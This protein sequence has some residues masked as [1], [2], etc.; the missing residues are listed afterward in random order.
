MENKG[1][2]QGTTTIVPVKVLPALVK[3][4]EIF[5]L[6]IPKEVQEKIE[7]I[8]KKISDVEWSGT[9]FY[10]H[11]GTI[12]GKDLLITALDIFVQDIGTAAYTEFDQS[13]DVISYACQ[14]PELLENE[15]QMGLIHSHNTMATFFSGTD[16]ATLNEEGNDRNHFVSLIV[17]NAGTYSAGITRKSIISQQIVQKAFYNTF[18]A[19]IIESSHEFEV[20]GTEIHWYAMNVITPEKEEVLDTEIDER[21]AEIKAE[22]AAK[23]AAAVKIIPYQNPYIG[24]TYTGYQG[25]M[26]YQSRIPANVPTPWPE[27]KWDDVEDED[28]NGWASEKN[29]SQDIK[30]KAQLQLDLEEEV[31]PYGK[32]LFDPEEITLVVKQLLSGNVCMSSK[33][34]VSIRQYAKESEKL[35]K[36]R[37]GTVKAF[38]DWADQFVEFLITNTWDP[39]I[40]NLGEESMAALCAYDA[41]QV[42]ETLPKNQFITE[43]I[44]M[45]DLYLI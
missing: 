17:N 3:K 44:H 29:P 33:D 40:L 45:L 6:T 8:C 30:D 27:K 20:S 39:T 4:T 34:T 43:Y 36:R 24:K 31:V 23:A 11:E 10:K 21:L 32:V 18:N 2:T 28:W 19:G 5:T 1:K 42:L 13:P 25:G 7:Y 38:K 22:K 26:G 12:E 14:H 41:Q 9:L 16:T 35:F 15:V 37:F